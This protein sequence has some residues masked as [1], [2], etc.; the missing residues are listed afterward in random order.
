MSR[1]TEVMGSPF[2]MF[3]RQQWS[4]VPGFGFPN[5]RQTLANGS[6]SSEEL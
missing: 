6:K 2:L 5:T 3:A 1:L 4:T